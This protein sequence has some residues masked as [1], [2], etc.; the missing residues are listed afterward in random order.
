MISSEW[1]ESLLDMLGCHIFQTDEWAQI[2]NAYGWRSSFLDLTFGNN[3]LA[4]AM[5]LE[6]SQKILPFFS[7]V[8]VLYIPR[9]PLADWDNLDGLIE[10]LARIER[11]ARE[12]KAIFIKIDPEIITGNGI[13]GEPGEVSND[14]AIIIEDLLRSR[15]WVFSRD[16]IQ[17]R[18]TV[19]IDLRQ[20]EDAILAKMKQKT[21]YNIKLSSKKGV[22]IRRG[23]KADLDRLFQLYA[24]TSLRDG[25]AIRSRE[26]YL[27]VWIKFIDASMAIP[28]IAEFEGTILAGL[29]LF[30]FGKKSW[31]L[32]G[33]SSDEHRDLMP[34]YGLQ[35]EA[36][37]LSKEM[38]CET[39]DLWGAP[40]HFDGSDRMTGVFRFKTGL[41]G[42]VVRMIGAWD[43]PV[44]RVKYSLYSIVL[45]K[46]LAVM[47]RKGRQ[48]TLQEAGG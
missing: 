16:Q 32:Y 27:D 10:L 18:N 15:G 33:M 5:V 9:G 3:R 37:Q 47:R 1:N 31:Y 14:Y 12:R 4:K 45:P 44:N 30:H 20:D 41:G 34:N 26:Y 6:R 48:A 21:R 29:F 19:W 25:F 46:I 28:L 35:W 40:E 38:G 39:Y 2:K 17:F 13:P 11:I 42:E 23:S 7:P 8:R 36:I 43:F 24:Q 22:I